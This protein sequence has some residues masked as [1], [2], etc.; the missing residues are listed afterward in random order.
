MNW[1]ETLLGSGA[2]IV[3]TL[4]L[5]CAAYTGLIVLMRVAGKRTISKWNAF[6]FVVT[7][8][9]GSSLA[10]VVLS[11]ETSLLQGLSALGAFILL[12]FLVTWGAMRWS[13][14]ERLAKATPTL[15]VRNGSMLHD[16]MRRERVPE[17]E[18]RAAVRRQGIASIEE[19]AAAVLETDGSISV[20]REA[21]P[22]RDSAL[23]DVEGWGREH[24]PPPSTASS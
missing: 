16:A 17:E 13:V 22:G 19:V 20:V 6:D 5:T 12:Q 4:V 10:S 2:A 1:E 14:V 24:G 9:L 21:V 7:V 8:A 3:R 15:L 11:R 23:S 18:V